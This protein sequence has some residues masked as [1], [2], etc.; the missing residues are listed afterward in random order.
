[1]ERLFS[2]AGPLSLSLF[3]LP[4]LLFIFYIHQLQGAL[5][6]DKDEI[7]E[8]LHKIKVKLYP[9]YPPNVEGDYTARTESEATL[10]IKQVCG[11]AITRGGAEG[12]TQDEFSGYVNKFLAEA[13]Y[14]LCDGYSVS[15]GYFSAHP[16]IG[17][18]FDTPS[19]AYDRNKHRI[20][21]KFRVLSKMRRLAR[22]I[23]VEVLGLSGANA[24]IDEFIDYEADSVNAVFV[25]GDQFA[26]HGHKIKLAGDGPGAG[27]FLVPADNPG[28]AVKVTRIAENSPARV[29]GALPS[30]ASGNVKQ[31][32]EIRAQYSSGANALLKGLRVITSPFVVEES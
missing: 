21:F 7:E 27:L 5:Y 23:K 6:A 18:A 26:L 14:Q 24:F 4:F 19:E 22:F 29:T 13:A 28:A 8:V 15:F 10:S 9:N 25:P 17:G 12:V 30:A 2:N 31:R 11:T 20:G 3:P 16:V 1:L 32:L